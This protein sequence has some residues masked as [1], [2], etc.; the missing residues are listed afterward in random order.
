[1][2]EAIITRAR[3]LE[4]EAQLYKDVHALRRKQA[5]AVHNA[6]GANMTFTLQ[7]IPVNLVDQGVAKG[8][9][10]LGIP[11]VNHQCELAIHLTD[12]VLG[13]SS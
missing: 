7:P 1:M 5:T 11:K 10:P 6:T 9:N 3:V 13:N 2:S 4:I 12:L 8:G